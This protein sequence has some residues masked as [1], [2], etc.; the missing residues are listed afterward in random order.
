MKR[1]TKVGVGALTALTAA[2]PIGQAA[3]AGAEAAG[4]GISRALNCSGSKFVYN[5]GFPGN[6][7]FDFSA[8][9]SGSLNSNGS[10]ATFTRIDYR[11]TNVK[12]TG[13]P[14]FPVKSGAAGGSSNVNVKAPIT[15][16]SPDSLGG[17]GTVFPAPFSVGNGGT[18]KIEGIPDIA[19]L[20]DPS[21]TATG[22]IGW[23]VT[24]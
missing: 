18:V 24:K 22:T 4:G 7:T 15:W 12:W 16:N 19:D 9:I 21:C 5:G 10:A 6:I 8:T 14:G 17:S 20:P 11:F 3:P 2:V 1:S 13:E 23:T